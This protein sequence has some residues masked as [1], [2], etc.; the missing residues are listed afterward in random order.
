M[1]LTL[2][3]AIL[4]GADS[5]GPKRPRVEGFLVSVPNEGVFR[6]DLKGKLLWSYPCRAYDAADLGGGRA[7]VTDRT[8]GRV[9]EVTRD[10]REVWEKTGLNSPTDADRLPNGNTLILENGAGRVLEV[11]PRGDAVPVAEGLNNP[12]DADRLPNG[13]TIV[14]DSGNNRIVEFDPGGREVRAIPDLPFPNNVL[15]LPNGHT[16]YTTYTS[17]TVAARDPENALLWE[18]KV[19]GILYSVAAEGDAVWVAEGRAGR[20]L[21][22]SRKGDVLAEVAFEKQFVDLAF[23]R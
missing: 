13:N 20:A 15:R 11:T 4:A 14:A 2:A 21:K 10:G 6:Y 7:L 5:S 9:F 18:H 23:C 16:L 8:A 19:D 22:L 1:R 12:Y 17:G 3:L